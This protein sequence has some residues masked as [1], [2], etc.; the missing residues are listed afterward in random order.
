[1]KW[2]EQYKDKI[3][4]PEEAVQVVKSGDFVRFAEVAAIQTCISL[5]SALAKRA[6]ELRGVTIETTLAKAAD[7]GLLAPGTEESWKTVTA[8]AND[9]PT[10]EKLSQR[11]NQT[12]FLPQWPSL[13][14]L[15]DGPFRKDQ[16]RAMWESEVCMVMISPPNEKGFV[17]FGSQLWHLRKQVEHAKFVIGEVNNSMPVIPGGDNWMPVDAFDYLVEATIPVDVTAM[18]SLKETPREEQEPSEVCCALMSE[19]INDGDTLMFGAGA[20]PMRLPPF[21]EHKQDLGCHTEII[22]PL[23]LMRK[24]VINNKRRNLCPGKTSCTA[25][26][27]SSPEDQAYL[28][29]NPLFDMR[30]VEL[31]NNPRYACQNNNFVAINAPLQI[32]LMGEISLERIGYRYFRGTG[33]QVEL[34][35]AALLSRGGRSIH[36]VVSR[37]LT[38]E[39]EWVSSIVPGFTQP[40]TVSIPR[41]LADFVVTEY[42]IAKLM[43]KTERERADELIAIAHPDFRSELKKEAQKLLYVV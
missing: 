40:A 4:A 29:G 12:D 6:P 32:N 19:L 10:V 20:I 38:A 13:A 26:A 24:G 2:Q 43:G 34:I 30:D 33:G 11:A 1:M 7:F 16:K 22:V 25:V 17:T 35:I 15:C 42:G 37:K 21:L 23:D 41:A 31:N 36:G 5:A 3:R 8:F 39:G 18:A 27:N 9:A 28:N 14:S